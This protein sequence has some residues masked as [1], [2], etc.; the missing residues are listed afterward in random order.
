MALLYLA[1]RFQLGM[2]QVNCRKLAFVVCT[3]S[4]DS[5]NVFTLADIRH[6]AHAFKPVVNPAAEGCMVRGQEN[7]HPNR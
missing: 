6:Y 3:E 5:G 1:I 7:W 2:V 4:L